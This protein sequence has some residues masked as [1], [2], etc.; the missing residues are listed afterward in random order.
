MNR[1]HLLDA[2][3][4]LALI[5][6]EPGADTVREIIEDCRMHAVHLAEVLRKLVALGMPLDEVIAR[7]ADLHLDL[8]EELN[9]GHVNAIAR[10]TPESKR[11]GLSLGDC[12]CLVIAESLDL[13]A[14]TAD[15]RW[16]EVRDRNLEILQIR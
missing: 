12:V 8:V 14:V 15:R 7:I 2:S 1:R 10:M 9:A 3:A 16:S 4:L 11:L 13:R 6:D 5:F